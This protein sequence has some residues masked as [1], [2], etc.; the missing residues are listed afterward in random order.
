MGYARD[1]VDSFWS[2]LEAGDLQ[3]CGQLIAASCDCRMPGGIVLGT[4]EQIVGMLEGYQTAFPGFR[5]QVVDAIE[6]SDQVA[7]ELR[8]TGTHAGP[9]ATPQ[10]EIPATG[11]PVVW[12][13][14]DVVRVRDGQITSWHS[15]YDQM[16]FMSQLGLLPTPAAP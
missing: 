16:A 8:V 1:I 14:T 13:S 10:G 6:E 11:Q 15:Y 12:E 5:H 2:R 9:L 7:L 3:G 4:P